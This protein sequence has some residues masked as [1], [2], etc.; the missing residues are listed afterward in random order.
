MSFFYC[1]Y[2]FCLFRGFS[3]EKT[4][5]LC[6]KSSFL[7]ENMR[8][9][10]FFNISDYTKHSRLDW[11]RRRSLTHVPVTHPQLQARIKLAKSG[12][13][14]YIPPTQNSAMPL[15]RN[16]KQT[17]FHIVI[18]TAGMLRNA[19]HLP[20]LLKTSEFENFECLQMLFR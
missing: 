16:L 7:G 12:K 9:S 20:V 4:H 15:G 5:N 10:F 19:S 2:S 13:I 8:T 6:K 1:R 14:L 11:Q 18:Q 3:K 17:H